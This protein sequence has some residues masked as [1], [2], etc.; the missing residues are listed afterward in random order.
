MGD[1]N[2]E[3]RPLH[4]HPTESPAAARRWAGGR[5]G[6]SARC[7]PSEACPVSASRSDT[8]SFG[9]GH[10]APAIGPGPAGREQPGARAV[11]PDPRGSD[12]PTA[13]PVTEGGSPYRVALGSR[14]AAL[15]PKGELRTLRDAPRQ[16]PA[17]HAGPGLHVPSRRAS[18]PHHG[19]RSGVGA[20]QQLRHPRCGPGPRLLTPTPARLPPGPLGARAV[21]PGG[22]ESLSD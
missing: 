6:W 22:E 3:A 17:F 9:P 20:Q 16:R 10:S 7:G 5:E 4:T 21:T 14:S 13:G 19:A 8:L 11:V 1:L 12:P 2:P 15:P 18:Q